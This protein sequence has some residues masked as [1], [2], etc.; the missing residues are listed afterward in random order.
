MAWKALTTLC[1]VESWFFNAVCGWAATAISWEIS[2]VVSMPDES[3]LIEKVL[4][5][6][7]SGA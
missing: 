4:T 7:S 1:S 5:C 6:I 2:E 3:P